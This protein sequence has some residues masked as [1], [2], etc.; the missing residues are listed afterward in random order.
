[1]NET[2][3]SEMA[4]AE[5]ARRELA[6]RGITPEMARAE[7]ERRKL[8]QQTQLERERAMTSL[9]QPTI[10]ERFL[11]FGKW[12]TTPLIQP[13]ALEKLPIEAVSKVTPFGSIAPF[14]PPSLQ[15]KIAGQEVSAMTSPLGAIS[16]LGIVK[17]MQKTGEIGRI[18]P[19]QNWLNPKNQLKLADE[20]RNSLTLQK[21]NLIK[22]YGQNYDRYIKQAQGQVSLQ[23]PLLNLIDNS[24]DVINTIKG[25]TEISE[26]IAKGEPTAKKVLNIVQTFMEKPEILQQLSLQE[27][28]GLQKYIRTLPGIRSKLARQYKM[29]KEQ[30]DFNNAERVL[31]DFA[32]DIKAQVLNQAPEMTLVNKEYGQF[33]TNLKQIRPYL[34]WDKAI[35]TFKTLHTKDPAVVQKLQEILPRDVM[36]K[37]QKLNWAE[38]G[39]T[40][41]KWLGGITAAGIVAKRIY[42]K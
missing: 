3:T 40:L 39:A 37:I 13:E 31:L 2:I 38:R 41:T 10:L 26:A 29:G 16:T 8:V 6:K 21:H 12:A 36:R 15:R 17:G 7:L 11:R 25:Q 33:M 14:L 19:L 5:L 23:E 28:D 30:V 42:S 27:A 9:P 34:K 32:N 24:D 18:A 22:K 35:T 4:R 1:M 20:A